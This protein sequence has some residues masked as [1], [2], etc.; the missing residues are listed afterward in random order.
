[1]NFIIDTHALIWHIDGNK[2]LK[3]KTVSVI[4]NITLSDYP[5]FS[6]LS[7]Y[8]SP[9]NKWFFFHV[10]VSQIGNGNFPESKLCVFFG[11]HGYNNVQCL[12]QST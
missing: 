4:E 7:S 12:F 1:M 11:F 5:L 8:N 10:N 6:F 3:K 9:F 2:K